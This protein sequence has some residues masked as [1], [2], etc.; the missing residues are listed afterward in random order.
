[1]TQ[2]ESI[3]AKVLE[4]YPNAEVAVRAEKELQFSLDRK[5]VNGRWRDQHLMVSSLAPLHYDD[6]TGYKDFKGIVKVET[7]SGVTHRADIGG[8]AMEFHDDGSR[9]FY[10][11]ADATEEFIDIAIPEYLTE[12]GWTPCAFTSFVV[13]DD[14]MTYSGTG[15]GKWGVDMRVLVSSWRTKVELFLLE[16]GWRVAVGFRFPFTLTGLHLVGSMLV[17]DRTEDVV[18]TLPDA[19]GYDKIG[20][21]AG[22]PWDTSPVGVPTL[23]D[24]GLTGSIELAIDM[25][26]WEYP[27]TID[28][29]IDVQISTTANDGCVQVGWNMFNNTNDDYVAYDNGRYNIFALYAVTIGS[30]ASIASAVIEFRGPGFAYNTDPTVTIDAEDADNPSAVTSEPDYATR[31]HTSAVVSWVFPVV[32]ANVA[33]YTPDFTAVMQEVID[34]PGRVSGDNVQIFVMG[35]SSGLVYRGWRDFSYSDSSYASRLQV[36]YSTSSPQVFVVTI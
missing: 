34:R 15:D 31:V 14:R 27:A 13:G 21:G 7:K 16:E 30:G 3:Y 29:S 5:L 32:T 26:E 2:A 19:V 35:P 22:S 17:S 4:D 8:Y 9:R 23:V 24:K 12:K 1:M 20:R 10:P 36:A 33:A 25:T 6:G 18:G 11:R 28:P